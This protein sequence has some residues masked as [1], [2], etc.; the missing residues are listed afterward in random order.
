MN[1]G[2][3]STPRG[4]LLL[5]AGTALGVVLL[6]VGAIVS[7]RVAMGKTPTTSDYSFLAEQLARRLSLEMRRKATE[8]GFEATIASIDGRRYTSEA[9]DGTPLIFDVTCREVGTG[10]VD[11]A[12]DG[13]N[14]VA[15]GYPAW[16][17]DQWRDEVVT[18][19]DGPGRGQQALVLGNC[20]RALE[21]TRDMSGEA[22]KNWLRTPTGESRYRIGDVDMSQMAEVVV[23]WSPADSVWPGAMGDVSRLVPIAE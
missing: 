19:T 15:A 13:D 10:D 23:S 6:V 4:A 18:I 9:P 2:T 3:T 22:R 12:T 11:G 14:L 7:A 21:V 20:G 16:R 1:L 5:K 17:R 8:R